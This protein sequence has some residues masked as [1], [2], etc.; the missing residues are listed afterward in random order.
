MSF[1]LSILCG[2]SYCL[3]N[4]SRYFRNFFV[5]GMS[6]EL[7]S[8]MWAGAI[9]S[10]RPHTVLL[11]KSKMMPRWSNVVVKEKGSYATLIT[12]GSMDCE[13]NA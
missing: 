9:V 1:A 4:C 11:S 6:D 5:C 10:C 12:D 7:R 3:Q 8:L 13:Q 2:M